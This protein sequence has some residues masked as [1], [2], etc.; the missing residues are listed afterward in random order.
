MVAG[1]IMALFE[2]LDVGARLSDLSDALWWQLTPWA[3]IALFM[4]FLIYRIRRHSTDVD[5]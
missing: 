4:A 3:L 1:F 5:D 2:A